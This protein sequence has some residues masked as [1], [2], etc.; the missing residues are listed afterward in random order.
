MVEYAIEITLHESF[1]N[2]VDQP[3]RVWV[4]DTYGIGSDSYDWAILVVEMDC[5]GVGVAIEYINKSP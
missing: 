1:F 2:T 3:D 4:C 5:T